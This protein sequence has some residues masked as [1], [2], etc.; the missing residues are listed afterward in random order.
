M[1]K[2]IKFI[3]ID[4][5]TA[6]HREVCCEICAIGL[7]IVY[8]SND[9]E[10]KYYLVKP[11]DNKYCPR[12]QEIHQITPYM[13][14]DAPTFPE[15]WEEIGH[16]FNNNIIVAHN[17]ESAEMTYFSKLLHNYNIS[18]PTFK[19]IC[20]NKMSKDLYNIGGLEEICSLFNI[21]I[22]T[23][24]NASDDA[25]SCAM[26]LIKCLEKHP[27]IC[28]NYCID[29]Y[30]GTF[31]EEYV[32]NKIQRSK[33]KTA[34]NKKT[35]IT[36]V[37]AADVQITEKEFDE[38]NYFYGK[39]ICITGNVNN[40]SRTDFF[41]NMKSIGAICEDC[42]KK[43]LDILIVGTDAGQSKINKANDY[44]KKGCDIEIIT[45]MEFIE[46]YNSQ[47]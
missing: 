14:I 41:Y 38:T 2:D 16:L 43:N 45:E 24:H 23:H 26:L 6:F 22:G 11:A 5:E 25:Y 35:T 47:N 20:T 44:I 46:I 37:K 32:F 29:K 17:A 13:T 39:H 9:V 33:Q 12:M 10:K 1:N 4:C 8:H 21:D 15:I 34:S 30:G 18:I 31:D 42:V 40:W 19:Y 27:N 7:S 28:E 36:H 3:A